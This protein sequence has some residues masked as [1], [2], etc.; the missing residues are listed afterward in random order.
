MGEPIDV[1]AYYQRYAPMVFRRCRT[2]LRSEES[3]MDAMQDVFIKLIDHRARLTAQA[4]SGLLLRM[5]TNVCL[6]RIRSNK[7][8]PALATSELLEQIALSDG[9]E[10][11]ST[12]RSVLNALFKTEPESSQTIAV[13][14]LVDGLTLEEVA[15]EVGMSVSGVRKRLRKLRA[16]LQEGEPSDA[17]V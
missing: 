12:A 8:Q 3:A 4:P 14:H 11:R 15:A 5:A 13:M 2:L 7:H 16:Q 1:E 10:G 9:A 6:N 17:Q